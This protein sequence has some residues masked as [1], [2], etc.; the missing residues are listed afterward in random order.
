MI[1]SPRL[2]LGLALLVPSIAV[3]TTGC[4]VETPRPHREVVEIVAPRAPPPVRYEVVPPPPAGRVEVVTW[5]PGHWHWNGHEYVWVPG[6]YVE[7]P[8]REAVWEPGHW[9][10]RPNGAWVWVEGHWR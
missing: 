8:R 9:A 6:H 5:D 4:V 1:L 10:E 2:L 7:R 3:S